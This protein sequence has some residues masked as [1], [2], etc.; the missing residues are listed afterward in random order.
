MGKLRYFRSTDELKYS[1]MTIIEYEICKRL[2]VYL[3]LINS[4]KKSQFKT[5]HHT[6]SYTI[7]HVYDALEKATKHQQ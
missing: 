5:N 4:T 1:I 6:P 2:K 7:I 3:N